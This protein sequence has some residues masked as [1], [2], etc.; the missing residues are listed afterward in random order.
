[1]CVEVIGGPER[2]LTYN[3][4]Q[5]LLR[6]VEEDLSV[7]RD[8]LEEVVPHPRQVTASPAEAHPLVELVALHHTA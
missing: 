7:P 5:V 1:M 3:V 4:R 6:P 2:L 8:R